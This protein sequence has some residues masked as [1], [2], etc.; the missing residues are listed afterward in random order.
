[1]VDYED[2]VGLDLFFVAK[3]PPK[4]YSAGLPFDK[5]GFML[6]AFWFILG[7]RQTLII[8]YSLE[9]N[10]SLFH[11]IYLVNP[12]SCFV[13]CPAGTAPKRRG[14]AFLANCPESNQQALFF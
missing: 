2:V 3:R 11:A 1:M 10:F 8:R 7:T 12:Q 14:E 4:E 13:A 5:F 9:V 6:V